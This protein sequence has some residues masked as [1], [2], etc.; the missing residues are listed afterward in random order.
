MVPQRA[1]QSLGAL[2]GPG[3]TATPGERGCWIEQSEELC[4]AQFAI[5]VSG[6]SGHMWGTCLLSWDL[7]RMKSPG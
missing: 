5:S 4:Q 2:G 3:P 6:A 1:G 7:A